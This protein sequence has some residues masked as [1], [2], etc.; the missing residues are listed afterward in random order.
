MKKLLLALFLIAFMWSAS[1]TQS[2]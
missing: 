2:A 1:G